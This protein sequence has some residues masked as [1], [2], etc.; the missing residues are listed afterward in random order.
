MTL[1]AFTYYLNLH[2]ISLILMAFLPSLI[3]LF[4]Y[5]RKDDHPEPTIVIMG[6]FLA[7]FLLPFFVGDLER[8]V[9]GWVASYAIAPLSF[10][11]LVSAAFIEECAKYLVALIV[12]YRNR[13]FDEPVDA[14]I[15]LIVVA[16][17]FA[18]SE[19]IIITLNTANVD[20]SQ[21]LVA[22]VSLR[23][24]GATLLH[25]LTSG[26]VGYFIARSH[27]LN[28]R[29]GIIRGLGFATFFHSVFNFFVLKIIDKGQASQFIPPILLLLIAGSI[30][31][32]KDFQRLK[33]YGTSA[34]TEL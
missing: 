6:L 18:A 9:Q 7:G 15:Y 21:S 1:L 34:L 13:E 10:G 25:T 27:F 30:I 11:F 12:Y 22:L 32:A 20:P 8:A 26:I 19:N 23:F 28:E 3:W 16:L 5:L 33:K 14:M 2:S 24:L 29:F 31:V 17:G 4:Y